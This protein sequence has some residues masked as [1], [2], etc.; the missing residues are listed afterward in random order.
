MN[1]F[2]GK[3][4][5]SSS[6]EFEENL[7][8][9]REI[10]FFSELPLETLK[11]LAYLGTREQFRAGDDLFHQDDDDGQAFYIISGEARLLREGGDDLVELREFPQ[12]AFLGSLALLG[13]ARRLFSLQ[14]RTDMDCLVLTR[15]KFSK[16]LAQFPGIAPRVLQ[17][18]VNSIHS[19]ERRSLSDVEEGSPTFPRSVGVSLL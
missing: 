2:E 5:S 15:E 9:L 7:S 11:V 16:A 19:W 14:A 8:I 13:N 1:S 17:T 3:N 4:D 18:L 10:Y 12:G 6:S